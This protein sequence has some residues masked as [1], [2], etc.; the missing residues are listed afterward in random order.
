MSRPAIGISL[1]P[2]LTVVSHWPVVVDHRQA[3]RGSRARPALVEDVDFSDEFC[4]F[5]QAY[6][7]TV[8]A[9]ELLLAAFRDPQ[10]A[11]Q[12]ANG[13]KRCALPGC[14]MKRCATG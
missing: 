6:L 7:P 4:R 14:S 12:P 8:E 9:A 10:A 11:V 5:V 2:Y 3:K 13:R 1:R